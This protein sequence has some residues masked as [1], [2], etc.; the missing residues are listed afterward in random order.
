MLAALL[1][2]D[3]GDVWFWFRSLVPLRCLM[4]L[5]ILICPLAEVHPRFLLP[6]WLCLCGSF[7]T[8]PL[9]CSRV[10]HGATHRPPSPCFVVLSA[11]A[12]HCGLPCGWWVLLGLC[13]THDPWIIVWMGSWCMIM[14]YEPARFIV[15]WW[16]SHPGVWCQGPL[17]WLVCAAR[18]WWVL[19]LFAPWW[20][21]QAARTYGSSGPLGGWHLPLARTAPL[22]PF[23]GMQASSFVL[24]CALGG[25]CAASCTS[26]PG[27]SL[28]VVL[29]HTRAHHGVLAMVCFFGLLDFAHRG[30]SRTWWLLVWPLAPAP[31]G[32]MQRPPALS[33][34]PAL[35]R[36][37]CWLV[38][39]D[40]AFGLGCFGPCHAWR[41][42]AHLGFPFHVAW[43]TSCRS[44]ATLRVLRC[45]SRKSPSCFLLLFLQGFLVQGFVKPYKSFLFAC[46]IFH[47]RT[48]LL[49]RHLLSPFSFFDFLYY[50]IYMAESLLAKLGDLN[51][52]AEEQ[53]AVVVVPETVAIPAEDFACSLLGRVLSFGPLDGG[54]VARLFRTIWKDEKVQNITEINPNFFLIAFASSSHRDNV[55][56]RGPWDFQKQWFALE[57]ADPACTI[58]DY[59]FQYM[60][61]WVRI[62][63]IPLSSMTE[64]LART[65]GACIGK[66]VMTDTRLEDGNMGEFLRVLVSLDTT[67]PLRRCVTLSRSNAKA[68]LCPHQYERVLIFCYGCG[69]IGHTP[70]RP[71]VA[72]PRGHVSVVKD[73]DLPPLSP[74]PSV[75]SSP[76]ASASTAAASVPAPAA[77]NA[78]TSV[79]VSAPVG[80][81]PFDAPVASG[82]TAAVL[83]PL[84]ALSTRG[85][86]SRALHFPHLDV[87][88]SRALR[89]PRHGVGL[90]AVLA[91]L[92]DWQHVAVLAFGAIWVLSCFA[93][94]SLTW[95][96]SVELVL[97]I[98]S[99]CAIMRFFVCCAY[100]VALVVRPSQ[101][102]S[103]GK[104]LA[105]I[106]DV[107]L[108]QSPKTATVGSHPWRTRPLSD[109][110]RPTLALL[111]AVYA[112]S[113]VLPPQA[114][115]AATVGSNPRALLV[116][117]SPCLCLVSWLLDSPL[118]G[119]GLAL[120]VSRFVVARWL[121][122]QCW[123]RGPA[124]H[125]VRCMLCRMDELGAVRLHGPASNPCFVCCADDV[126]CDVASRFWGWLALVSI[127]GSLA[128]PHGPCDF[129]LPL[130]GGSSPLSVAL[131]AM[132]LWLVP[133]PS[134]AL[135]PAHSPP[136]AAYPAAGG[137]C[138]AY[139]R[140]MIHGLL[141]GWS[142]VHDY[143]LRTCSFHRLVVAAATMGVAA[144]TYGSSG[145]PWWLALAARTYGSP[146][147][148][149]WHACILLCAVLCT[150][151]ILRY[152]L[153]KPSRFSLLVV[154]SHTRAHHGVLAMVCFFGLLDFAHRGLSRTWWLLAWPHLDSWMYSSAPMGLWC[155]A[156]CCDPARFY[157]PMVAPAP[158]GA[159]PRPAV[160]SKAPALPRPPV[161]AGAYRSCFWPG[162]FRPLPWLALSSP[163]GVS[164]PR[165]LVYKLPFSGRFAGCVACLASLLLVS[166]SYSY[167][168]SLSRVF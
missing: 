121:L 29:S 25:F 8:L 145:P 31:K 39:T 122:V 129:D 119:A 69:L 22:A 141:C 154:L 44:R 7:H 73:V 135:L 143:A 168:V 10:W 94:F 37:P 100:G 79:P 110:L 157:A 26:L 35:P 49:C 47:C 81:T 150:W 126:G 93:S 117:N 111:G 161:L 98:S 16:L 133:P 74:A 23:L 155:M 115:L 43:C 96:T 4:A 62:H 125:S 14:R 80:P 142:V 149:S 106:T 82:C 15:S 123:L 24:F 138:L 156:V 54:R 55:L 166:F 19:S 139:A 88:L 32:A 131:V 103:C 75:A 21:A 136:T 152:F 66:V 86:H 140:P 90:A 40:R 13:A 77:S 6:S 60:C 102:L 63:N 107:F 85:K 3:S 147:P 118:C 134:P 116:S 9:P 59:A 17:R 165:C 120:I 28:M 99:L 151:W 128:M 112:A 146:G 1:L 61:I 11:L 71:T 105:V 144:R 91:L 101:R 68:I 53:D 153:R 72:R 76:P 27:F 109:C 87:G 127:A 12:S 2:A 41:F 36:P 84:P 163:S 83:A 95:C 97:W 130:S 5:A 148:V 18:D 137:C 67:K 42:L 38:R 104:G 164:L 57:P 162:V 50:S 92:S 34:A 160:L 52:T 46:R 20:L 56:K 89:L 45:L 48:P 78:A 132:S 33:K 159:L 64:A 51:F 65:L 158:R 108:E 167:K 113:F 124:L 58:H 30:L 70:K 114:A